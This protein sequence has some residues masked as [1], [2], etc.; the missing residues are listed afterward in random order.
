MTYYND[1]KDNVEQVFK[2]MNEFQQF[3]DKS[4]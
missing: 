2:K 4:L 3:H 1:L